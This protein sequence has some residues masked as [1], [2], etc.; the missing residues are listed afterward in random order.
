MNRGGTM[1]GC[2]C[3]LRLLVPHYNR[4]R[5]TATGCSLLLTVLIPSFDFSYTVCP[6]GK[7]YVSNR[8]MV[9]KQFREKFAKKSEITSTK[10]AP[11]LL[12]F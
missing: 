7:C 1:F 11:S 12:G 4:F 3:Y 10:Q 6:S 9:T 2:L 8:S 5:K